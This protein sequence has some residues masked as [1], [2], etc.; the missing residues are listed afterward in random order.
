MAKNAAN[1]QWSSTPVTIYS[2]KT[3]PPKTTRS[4]IAGGSSDTPLCLQ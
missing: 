1:M 4:R 3:E 2:V